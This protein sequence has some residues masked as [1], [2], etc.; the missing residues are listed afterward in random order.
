[1]WSE[2]H[3]QWLW[4]DVKLILSHAELMFGSTLIILDIFLLEEICKQWKK[5]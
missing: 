1:M 2:K 4:V 3:E 5:N